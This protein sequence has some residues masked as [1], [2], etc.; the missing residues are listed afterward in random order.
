MSLLAYMRNLKSILKFQTIHHA[1]NNNNQTTLRTDIDAVRL[2]FH[3]LNNRNPLHMT[4]NEFIGAIGL[5]F[6][7]ACWIIGSA[8]LLIEAID[9]FKNKDK[10]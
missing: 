6:F 7:L 9:D 2:Y 10:K 5:Y 1:K 3:L 4:N 8:Y